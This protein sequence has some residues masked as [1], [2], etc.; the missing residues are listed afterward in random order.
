MALEFGADMVYSQ[1][2]IDRKL[3]NTKRVIN[4]KLKTGNSS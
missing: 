4:D 2:L 3:V 1:E